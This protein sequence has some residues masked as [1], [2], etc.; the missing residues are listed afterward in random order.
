[1][2]TQILPHCWV[3]RCLLFGA[4]LFLSPTSPLGCRHLRAPLPLL[5]VFCSHLR[6]ST[7]PPLES[8]QFV[9]LSVLLALPLRVLI[10]S[11]PCSSCTLSL[12]IIVHLLTLIFLTCFLW[13]FHVFECMCLW[14]CI[15]HL[16]PRPVLP[17]Q[18]TSSL[19]CRL[20]LWLP[21]FTHRL[22]DLVSVQ[23]PFTQFLCL[24]LSLILVYH[25]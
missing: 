24:V 21:F 1:M 2:L 22:L 6:L 13:V 9:F 25:V 14:G 5:S 10:S 4:C 3:L 19:Y 18:R 15:L 17:L 7:S 8:H 23:Q 16:R 11:S 12:C 20:F